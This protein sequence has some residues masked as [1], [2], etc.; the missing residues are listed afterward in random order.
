MPWNGLFISQHGVWYIV[1]QNRWCDNLFSYKDDNHRQYYLIGKGM[2]EIWSR[3]SSVSS[4]SETGI[5]R[6]RIEAVR[7]SWWRC[8]LRTPALQ[9]FLF[10]YNL[11]RIRLLQYHA[12]NIL[13]L[14]QRFCFFIRLLISHRITDIKMFVVDAFY[15]GISFRSNSRDLKFIFQ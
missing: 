1:F 13:S 6:K 15:W 4:P 12:E 3:R 2:V 11:E 10:H 7:I 5:N 14:K 8:C 9:K